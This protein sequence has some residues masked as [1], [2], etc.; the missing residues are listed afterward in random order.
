[1][2]IKKYST[3]LAERGLD[4]DPQKIEKL[5]NDL[6]SWEQKYNSLSAMLKQ[7]KD[8]LHEY[9]RSVEILKASAR[10]SCEEY[11][12]IWNEYAGI[13]SKGKEQENNNSTV[14]CSRKKKSG[15]AHDDR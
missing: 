12:H 4:K 14:S 10:G 8:K 1:M 6:V 13:Q 11:S 15:K 5:K 3:Y 7:K 2:L 9:E